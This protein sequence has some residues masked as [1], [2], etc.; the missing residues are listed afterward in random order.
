MNVRESASGLQFPEGPV[1]LA[2]DYSG[3]R[4][5]RVNL[6]TGKAERVLDRVGDL[7]LKGPDGLVFD[8]DG[9]FHFTDLGKVREHA[10]DRGGVFYVRPDGSGART[11]VYPADGLRLPW[12]WG[13]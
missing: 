4:I 2:D 7:A 6:A 8:A 5:E 11:V 1:A 9:G 10:M 3:G 13:R 12:R